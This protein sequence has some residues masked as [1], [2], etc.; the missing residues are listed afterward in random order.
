EHHPNGTTTL[1]LKPHPTNNKAEFRHF[2]PH[3][4]TTTRTGHETT[5]ANNTQETHPTPNNNT[6]PPTT[7]HNTPPTT[8]DNRNTKHPPHNN[9]QSAEFPTPPVTPAK[10]P[11]PPLVAPRKYAGLSPQELGMDD[12][13]F[14]D[15]D[16]INTDA[17]YDD[18]EVGER[19]EEVYKKASEKYRRETTCTP[20]P[21]AGF[22]KSRFGIRPD[23][24]F[25]VRRGKPSTLR[26]RKDN[27]E[28]YRYD[29][30]PYE[31]IFLEGFRPWNN[32][33]P[34]SMRHYMKYYQMTAFVSAT[35]AEKGYVPSWAVLPRQALLS[36][37]KARRYVLK[38]P[39]GI[40]LLETL[41]TH[42]LEIQ[43]EVVFWKGIRPE[44]ID[45]FEIVNK[46]GKILEVVRRDEWEEKRNAARQ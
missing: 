22:G 36:T 44:F 6:P 40:D 19:E 1:Y 23:R 14:S 7:N 17:R 10:P 13:D 2:T 46:K 32:K 29:S 12:A 26:Y 11:E 15:S 43:Q 31:T 20:Q 5:Q 33:V 8:E 37:K 45:R 35:R 24:I 21:S 3:H 39:G 25:P 16:D 9:L 28:L 38:A 27:E 4:P 34:R 18:S 42:S 30:R 41:K